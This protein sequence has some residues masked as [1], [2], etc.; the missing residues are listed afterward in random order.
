MYIDYFAFYS[1]FIDKIKNEKLKLSLKKIFK[2]ENI[3]QCVL[4]YDFLTYTLSEVELNEFTFNFNNNYMNN[5]IHQEEYFP[6][7]SKI[8]K[9]KNH[10]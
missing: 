10:A 6:I 2:L 8:I 4:M 1:F 7:I 3:E 9:S 5:F